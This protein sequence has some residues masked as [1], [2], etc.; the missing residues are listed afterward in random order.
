[1]GRRSGPPRGG[2]W[3]QV[4]K[5]PKPV[6]V[7]ASMRLREG[8]QGETDAVGRLVIHDPAMGRITDNGEGILVT[9][10]GQEVGF[11]DYTTG[12]FSYTNNPAPETTVV[13]EFTATKRGK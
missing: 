3:S 6:V 4:N 13:T 5:G 10:S 11:V 9:E 7:D 12:K 2:L 1:M 8:L